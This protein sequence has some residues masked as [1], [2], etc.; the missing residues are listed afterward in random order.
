[1][2][3]APWRIFDKTEEVMK[4]KWVVLFSM[5]AVMIIFLFTAA[6]A[7]QYFAPPGYKWVNRGGLKEVDGY[8]IAMY[9]ILREG[10]LV[11]WRIYCEDDPLQTCW[12]IGMD[13]QVLDVNYGQMREGSRSDSTAYDIYLEEE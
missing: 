5:I 8:A 4:G 12:A 1:M 10:Q 2:N 6:Y 11:G 13:G 7:L 9:P 3:W